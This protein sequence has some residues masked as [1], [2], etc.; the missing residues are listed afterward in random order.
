MRSAFHGSGCEVFFIQGSKFKVL[1]ML[2]TKP[3]LIEEE[4]PEYYGQE[5][6]DEGGND[7]FH[8]DAQ[9]AELDV[10]ED[11]QDDECSLP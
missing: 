5:N 2:Q 6:H 7:G 3:R 4:P 1:R 11:E 8:S 10:V 9:G